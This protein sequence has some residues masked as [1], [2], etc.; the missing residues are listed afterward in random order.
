MVSHVGHTS[1]GFSPKW[2]SSQTV[3]WKYRFINL[4]KSSNYLALLL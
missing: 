4:K 2:T 1:G 3:Q